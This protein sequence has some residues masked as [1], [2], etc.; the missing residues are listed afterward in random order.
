MKDNPDIELLRLRKTPWSQ[1]EVHILL[2]AITLLREPKQSPIRITNG[3]CFDLFI[4]LPRRQP[5]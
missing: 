3:F 2:D 5:E 1:S 4:A